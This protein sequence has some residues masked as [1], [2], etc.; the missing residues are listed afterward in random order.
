MQFHK[1][2]LTNQTLMSSKFHNLLIPQTPLNQNTLL[3]A[4][5]IKKVNIRNHLEPEELLM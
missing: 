2:D 5:Q 4:E 3:H 1:P